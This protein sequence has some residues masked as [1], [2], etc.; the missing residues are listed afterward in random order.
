MMKRRIVHNQNRFRLGPSSA[1]LKKL[2]YKV[3]EDRSIRGTLEDTREK[4]P[5]LGIRRQNLISL[6]AVEL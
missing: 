3:L 1:V 5:I 2:S 4:D 6:V